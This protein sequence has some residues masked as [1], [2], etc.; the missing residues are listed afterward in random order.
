MSGMQYGTAGHTL[1]PQLGPLT[2]YVDLRN[3]YHPVLF[4]PVVDSGN[5]AGCT[6]YNNVLLTSDPTAGKPPPVCRRLRRGLHPALRPG[7]HQICVRRTCFCRSWR[8]SAGAGYKLAKAGLAVRIKKDACCFP[9]SIF[10]RVLTLLS[11]ILGGVFR[12]GCFGWR[13][14]CRVAISTL[15]HGV[16]MYAAHI[17]VDQVHNLLRGVVDAGVKQRFGIPP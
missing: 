4:G 8:S 15:F 2:A 9:T 6:D 13:H 14:R 10:F 16:E 7:R 12:L 3:Y 11:R 5:P 17:V 1:D